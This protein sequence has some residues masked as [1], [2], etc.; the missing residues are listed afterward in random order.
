MVRQASRRARI[1]L[2]FMSPAGCGDVVSL[3]QH[4]GE[5]GDVVFHHLNPNAN[6]DRHKLQNV[7]VEAAYPVGW[8]GPTPETTSG[9]VAAKAVSGADVKLKDDV[10]AAEGE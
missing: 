3:G 10:R 5:G 9:C 4:A 1:L 7:D 6:E 8:Q 2:I